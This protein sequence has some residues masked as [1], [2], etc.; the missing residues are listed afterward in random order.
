MLDAEEAAAFRARRPAQHRRPAVLHRDADRP[1]AMVVDRGALPVPPADRRAR[2]RLERA[3]LRRRPAARR[4]GGGAP[5]RGGGR[6]PDFVL[7][8]GPGLAGVRADLALLAARPGRCRRDAAAVADGRATGGGRARRHRLLRPRPAARAVDRR[9]V[10]GGGRVRRGRR[11][12]LRGELRRLRRA[13]A[14]APAGGG[15]RVVAVVSAIGHLTDGGEVA[16]AVALAPRLEEP[17]RGAGRGA[18][19]A[20]ASPE[21]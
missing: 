5:V 18:A 8:G 12:R 6:C 11:A 17:A 13:G 16:L 4:A 7:D 20:A 14:R 3:A 2:C 19:R 21:D 15:W 1:S 9:R 10:P